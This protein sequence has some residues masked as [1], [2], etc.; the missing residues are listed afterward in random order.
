MIGK[1]PL[2][3][4]LQKNYRLWGNSPYQIISLHGGPG[5]VGGLG[6]LS[7]KLGS[8]IGIVEYLQ[9]KKT[10]EEEL[11]KLHDLITS[12]SALPAILL[13]HSWGAVLSLLFA[14]RYSSLLKKIIL[15]GCPPLQEKYVEQL[16]ATRWKRISA[17][18]EKEYQEIGKRMNSPDPKVREKAFQ[19][20]GL[21]FEKLDSF[22]FD[23]GA[24][25]EDSS[26]YRFSYDISRSIWNEFLPM[27]KNGAFLKEISKIETEMVFIHGDYDPHPVIGI[28]EPLKSIN[29]SHKFYVLK[30]CGHSPW[31]EKQA[32]DEFFKI[33]YS[34]LGIFNIII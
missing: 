9:M 2:G 1:N 8:R 12:L 24:I 19:E 14:A 27:R 10:I 33:L 3:D 29:K 21:F 13:G 23:E 20:F 25:N 26:L 5:A 6:P 30:D 17:G 32:K 28:E 4:Y 16:S 11:S 34:E 15:I 22:S 31:V 7:K 18:Y